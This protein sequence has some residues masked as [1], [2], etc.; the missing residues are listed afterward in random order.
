[1]EATKPTRSQAN[2]ARDNLRVIC[3]KFPGISGYGVTWDKEGNY[4][5]R[6][7]VAPS[8]PP[9]VLRKIPRSVDGVPVQIQRMSKFD[10]EGD[11][12]RSDELLR[13]RAGADPFV[14]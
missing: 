1:M 10:L 5:V 13:A 6:V 12:G 11:P 8:A 2:V 9:N 3:E 7:N 4:F 14:P